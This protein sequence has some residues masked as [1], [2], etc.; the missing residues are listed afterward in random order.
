M[1]DTPDRQKVIVTDDA[2]F[3]VG[4]WYYFSLT[5]SK[6]GQARLAIWDTLG[7]IVSDSTNNFIVL[8]TIRRNYCICFGVCDQDS[9]N[10]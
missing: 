1:C 2:L 7:P 10:T 4:K 3:G 9:K 6:E 8:Q 5:V